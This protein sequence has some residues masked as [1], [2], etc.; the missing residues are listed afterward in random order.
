MQTTTSPA[1]L[2]ERFSRGSCQLID[3]RE[4]V[5]HAEMYIP[6]ARLIPLGELEKRA[7]EISKDLPVVIHCRSGKRGEQA[8]SKLKALGFPQVE[9][10]TGGIL[11]WKEAGLPVKSSEQ[12]VFPLMQQ[13]QLII[14]AGVWLGV[15]LALT[16]HPYWA[17]LCAF[18]AS[19]LLLAGSTGWCGLA[20]L[21]SKMPWN[22]VEGQACCTPK[23]CA[24][25]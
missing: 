21:L 18:F 11:A 23:N 6:G 25:N 9:N 10:L 13:V 24:V 20:I 4:P 7:S 17:F 15:I 19:G 14:G 1:E 3:V 5:E 16:V 2:N 8:L 12:K 22:R